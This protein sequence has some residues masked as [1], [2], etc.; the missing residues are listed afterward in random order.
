MKQIIFIAFI[1]L[2]SG[3]ID[4]Y[5][6][7]GIEE[8]SDLLVIEGTITD[9]ESR[10][11]LRRSV[12]LSEKLTGT[13]TVDNA[14]LYV[15]NENGEQIN[16]YFT[17]KGT[18]Q[19]PT[20]QLMPGLKYRLHIS[21]GGEEYESTFLAPLF[22][23]EIDS[24]F[25]MKRGQGEPVYMCVSTHD[26]LNQSRYYL[27]SFKEHWEVTAEL[28]ANAGVDENGNVVEFN[29]FT[30]NN[31]YYCWGNDSSK[32][33]ILDSS[34]K[35]SENIIS[36][37]RLTEIACDNDKLSV[38]YY[39][40]VQQKQIRKEAYDYYSNLQKNIEQTGSIFAPVPSEMKGN[41]RC[42]TNPDLPVI[43]YIDVSTITK[44]DLFIPQEQGLYEAPRR[45]CYGM[46][47]EDP[48]FAYPAYGYYLRMQMQPTQWAPFSC[49]DCR[50]KYRASKN[51]PDFWPNNHL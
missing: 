42:I 22:T 49:V 6:P 30:S 36:Q 39:I 18:Y 9:N 35:L 2:L 26:P 47:T 20:I 1:L 7:K 16:G 28:A 31:T 11:T 29:L 25:P 41:I 51:K 38:L 45:G 33:L 34:E 10:F 40:D 37:K 4:E 8:V 13:E 12:G 17:G 19:V 46:I 43:G 50:L 23:P 21:I 27:W 44:K 3:C 48:D 32:I 5:N 14:S 24:V 15:E